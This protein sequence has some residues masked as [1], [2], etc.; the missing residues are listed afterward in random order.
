MTVE[1]NEIT[2]E[3]APGIIYQTKQNTVRITE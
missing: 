1:Y 3:Q 2:T